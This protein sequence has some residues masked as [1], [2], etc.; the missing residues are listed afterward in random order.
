MSE[1]DRTSDKF[2]WRSSE[3]VRSWL[4]SSPAACPPLEEYE[5]DQLPSFS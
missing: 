3:N 5:T 4:D 2:Q 1:V